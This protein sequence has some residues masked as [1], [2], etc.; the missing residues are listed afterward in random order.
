MDYKYRDFEF[1]KM[2][3]RPSPSSETRADALQHEKIGSFNIH[4]AQFRGG[5]SWN[6]RPR[7]SLFGASY[8]S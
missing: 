5:L 1:R 4:H 3:E 6:V 2:F 8:C 7:L